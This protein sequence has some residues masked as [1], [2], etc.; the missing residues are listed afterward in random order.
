MIAAA[1]ERIVA[2]G[3]VTMAKGYQEWL[4]L[5]AVAVVGVLLGSSKS[6]WRAFVGAVLF[7]LRNGLCVNSG[8][9]RLVVSMQ[10]PDRTCRC[11]GAC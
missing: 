2:E 5:A 3:S 8:L 7:Q 4:I 10:L 11:G 1:T 9:R 6:R